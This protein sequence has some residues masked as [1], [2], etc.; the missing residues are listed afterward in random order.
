[1]RHAPSF[2]RTSAEPLG[3][4]ELPTS[5]GDESK[6]PMFSVLGRPRGVLNDQ[7]TYAD[8]QH[9]G[10][11]GTSLDGVE[12]SADK[13]PFSLES[14]P[15]V[16]PRVRLSNSWRPRQNYEI[17]DEDVERAQS[18]S[19]VSNVDHKGTAGRTS[20]SEP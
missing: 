14:A 2:A 19:G 11:K 4:E 20:R 9:E 1:M 10:K 15:A 6:S 17:R 12:G 8:R 3:K 18:L 7:I 16:V 5:A 13:R